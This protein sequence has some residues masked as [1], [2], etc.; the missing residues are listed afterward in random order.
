MQAT[1]AYDIKLV[2]LYGAAIRR[3]FPHGLLP[4]DLVD[5]RVATSW[6]MQEDREARKRLVAGQAGEAY[7]ADLR[8]RYLERVEAERRLYEEYAARRMNAIDLSSDSD[9]DA[10]D[11]GHGRLIGRLTE[12]DLESIENETDG[13]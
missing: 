4:L 10:D 11:E 3:N 12:L 7:M 2:H 8:R 6:E 9:S 1:R 13:E 5:P